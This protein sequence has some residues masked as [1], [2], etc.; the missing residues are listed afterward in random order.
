MLMLT[1]KSINHHSQQ[2]HHQMAVPESH[3]AHRDYG[4]SAAPA[5]A[6]G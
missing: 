6:Q 2:A 3:A 5:A 1:F 4:R